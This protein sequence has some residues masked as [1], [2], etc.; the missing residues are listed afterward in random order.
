MSPSAQSYYEELYDYTK[1]DDGMVILNPG[2]SVPESY[3]EAADI[4]IVYENHGVP[5]GITSN[6]IT[7]SML[8]ALPYGLDASESEFSELSDEV[9]YLYVSPDWMEVASSLGEQADWAD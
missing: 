1:A 9:G 3:S 6:G 2:A 5:S 4:I 8:G 7:E